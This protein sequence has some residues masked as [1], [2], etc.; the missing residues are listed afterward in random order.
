[1]RTLHGEGWA[2]Q[3]LCLPEKEEEG[4][5]MRRIVMLAVVALM[6]ALMRA[7]SGT[8]LAAHGEPHEGPLVGVCARA[9]LAIFF[10]LEREGPNP[11]ELIPTYCVP[12]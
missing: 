6:M 12:A 8:A 4:A 2:S 5:R 1:M 7:L 10:G 3:M 9:A 11:G